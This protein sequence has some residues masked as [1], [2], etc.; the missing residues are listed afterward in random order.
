MLRGDKPHEVFCTAAW[1]GLSPPSDGRAVPTYAAQLVNKVT[2]WLRC[3]P[4]APEIA[5]K[6]AE[7]RAYWDHAHEYPEDWAPY[8]RMIDDAAA[9]DVPY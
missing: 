8:Q 1:R 5:A 2:A 9:H 6:M 3:N 4:D 7:I